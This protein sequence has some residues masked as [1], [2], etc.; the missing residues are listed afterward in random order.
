VRS[1]FLSALLA[2]LAILAGAVT[3]VASARVLFDAPVAHQGATASCSHCD[4]CDGK[5][6]CPMPMADCVQV[7]ANAA[8]MVAV[9]TIA[10]PLAIDGM[11][12]RWPADMSLTGLSPPPDP[13][14]PRS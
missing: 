3:T 12:Y 4:D 10:L 9:A 5:V 13:F 6:P 7:H 2:C 8:P 14:P 11:A 1:S